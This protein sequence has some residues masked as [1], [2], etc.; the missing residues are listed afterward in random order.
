MLKFNYM[1][2]DTHTIHYKEIDIATSKK[3]NTYWPTNIGTD[4]RI[5]LLKTFNNYEYYNKLYDK[6]S[7]KII[8]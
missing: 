7:M 5:K 3:H 6:N 4:K 2:T 1:T 8:Y